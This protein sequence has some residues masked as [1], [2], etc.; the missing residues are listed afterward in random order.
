MSID[1]SSDEKPTVSLRE[2]IEH[3]ETSA[4]FL[5]HR[6]DTIQSQLDVHTFSLENMRIRVLKSSRTSALRKLL[7]LLEVDEKTLTM[8]IFL[9]RLNRY[10][11]Q[12]DFIDLNDLYIEISPLLS[13][14]FHFPPSTRKVP[15][16]FLLKELKN[17]FV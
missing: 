13:I 4:D 8:G 2:A 1:S 11:I 16:S 15:Y 14:V 6:L 12:N 17:L 10:L 3:L 9:R 7:G 5:Q